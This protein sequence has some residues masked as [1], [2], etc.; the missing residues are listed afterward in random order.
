MGRKNF[1]LRLFSM[2]GITGSYA[3]DVDGAGG[4]DGDIGDVDITDDDTDADDPNTQDPTESDKTSNQNDNNNDD[5]SKSDVETLRKQ[6]E[7]LQADKEKRENETAINN[8]IAEL[9]SKHTG[10]DDAKVKEYLTELNK[11]DPGKAN[12]LNNPV[13]WE[14]VWLNEFASKE[15]QNDHPSFGR[16]VAP[17]DRSEEFNQKLESGQGLSLDEQANYFND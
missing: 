16:N 9:Q 12:M 15:V 13:G 14:N 7:D 6:V 8:A 11:T 2:L 1:L 3:V 10:F 4:G 17:V 5:D